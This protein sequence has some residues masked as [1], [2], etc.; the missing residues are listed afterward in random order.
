MPTLDTLV[1]VAAAALVFALVPG[2]AVIYIVTR[3][4]DQDRLAGLVS[5][6]GVGTGNLVHVGAAG[7][8]LSA[9]L[10]SSAIAF[11]VVKYS[12]AAYLAYLGVRKL[13][14]R[15]VFEDAAPARSQPLLR[16]YWQGM[17]VALLN[18]K[19]ALFFLSF[20]PQFVDPSRGL[21]SLQIVVLGCLV[22]AVTLASDSCY[23]V[24][25]G[26]VG[27][28]LRSSHRV[29]RGQQLL[30]GGVYIALGLFTAFTGSKSAKN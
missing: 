28:T 15:T 8:G 11:D 7:V 20:L 16:V 19:T 23:A 6:L 17:V 3:S 25:S 24:L 2:P 30:S 1:L 5:G 29:L 14:D 9:L 27:R 10:A 22:V 4:V 12:G 21:V 26:T 18:P 13:T